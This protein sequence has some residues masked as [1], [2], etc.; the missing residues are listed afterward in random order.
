MNFST[1]DITINGQLLLCIW[2]NY[3]IILY[4]VWFMLQFIWDRNRPLKLENTLLNMSK[5]KQFNEFGSE[6]R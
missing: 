2:G 1:H 4:T 3:K 5:S 6:M